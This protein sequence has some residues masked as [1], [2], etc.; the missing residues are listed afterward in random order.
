MRGNSVEFLSLKYL[1][2]VKY[3]L[4]L[5]YPC[6]WVKQFSSHMVERGKCVFSCLL[7]SVNVFLLETTG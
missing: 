2:S 3:Q 7:L 6:F 4:Y 5:G 1:L